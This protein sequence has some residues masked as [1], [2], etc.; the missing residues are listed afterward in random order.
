[1]DWTDPRD[2]RRQVQKLWDRGIL[3]KC[4]AGEGLSFPHRLR[5]QAPSRRELTERFDEVRRWIAMLQEA[6]RFRLEMQSI[7]HRVLG[8]NLIPQA[9][10]IDR[11]EDAL[12][13]LGKQR[14][15]ASFAALLEL[16][17]SRRSD[18]LPWVRQYPLKALALAA[19]WSRLLDV[20]EWMLKHP[21]PGIYLR[22]V[23][24]PGV[25]SKF[26]ETHRGTLGAWLDRLLP[27]EAVER[28]GGGESFALRYGFLEK[29]Q[30]LRFRLLD[31]ASALLPGASQDFSVTA[32][33]F[34]ELA[35]EPRLRGK[36]RRV[37]ITENEINF[38]AL[39]ALSESLAVF[40]AGYGF[41][42]L[43]D[44]S[45]LRDVSVYY[46]GDIDTHGF[47]ILDQLRAQLPHAQSILMDRE[48][49][50]AHRPFWGEEA[51]PQRRELSRLTE[52]EQELYGELR[53][54]RWAVNLRLEQERIGFGWVKNSLGKIMRDPRS[55]RI[56]DE[57][58][59]NTPVVI[60]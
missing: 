38:L 49:L 46:W 48:T 36:V 57:S 24:I 29:P 8:K 17:R 28:R 19:P 40:G 33:S 12:A 5:L 34:C 32:E 26:I 15:A 23:D 18:L 41:D 53:A 13:L 2:L 45:W 56:T 54:Q 35:A 30:R 3:L 22:Q 59:Q 14:E 4:L 6:R 39:P 50:L 10:W 43:A 51:E 52:A 42:V 20:V 44:V 1:M 9:V 47:A 37:F 16:T 27:S 60:F 31:S 25:H 11:V 55:L 21:R 58:S 7:Q